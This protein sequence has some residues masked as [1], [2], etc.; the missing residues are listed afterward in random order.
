M[1]QF[2]NK[3]VT[4]YEKY[5]LKIYLSFFVKGGNIGNYADD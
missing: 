5:R 3:N 1:I 2:N 4:V